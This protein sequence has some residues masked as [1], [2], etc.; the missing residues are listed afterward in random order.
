[1]CAAMI[2][3]ATKAQHETSTQYHYEEEIQRDMQK[4]D[5]ALARSDSNEIKELHRYLD[6]K[7]QAC[8]TGWG[9]S[10]FEYSKGRGFAYGYL[11]PYE[12]RENLS[13][14][15]AKLEAFLHG[16]NKVSRSADIDGSRDVNVTVNNTVN[17]SISFE[18]ARKQVEDMSS[19]TNEQTQEVLERIDEIERVLT[20]DSSKKSKWEQVKPVLKWLMDKSYDLVKIILPLLLKIE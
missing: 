16:W 9:D 7:Y 4:I 17:I 20:T 11:T 14:M 10:M 2:N 6:G 19:L 1:M 15:K 12:L 8:I 5:D 13:L 18:E 3:P